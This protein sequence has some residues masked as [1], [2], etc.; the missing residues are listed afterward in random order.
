MNETHH[1]TFEFT[2][3]EFRMNAKSKQTW[4]NW[5]RFLP[6]TPD[7]GYKQNIEMIHDNI[8]RTSKKRAKGLDETQKI[9]KFK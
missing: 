2:P 5:L 6:K 1:D 4:K 9:V 7:P 8:L 3:K